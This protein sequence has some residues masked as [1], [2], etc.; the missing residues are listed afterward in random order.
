MAKRRSSTATRPPTPSARPDGQ[1]AAL[2]LADG[3]DRVVQG[4]LLAALAAVPL[5]FSLLD[6]TYWETDKAVLLT[7]FA[8]VAGA[9]WLLGTL[10]RPA[11][12]PLSPAARTL[13]LL[14]VAVYGAYVLGTILSINPQY[15]LFGSISRHEGLITRTA[16][17]VF[18]VCVLTRVR[19]REQI[20]RTLTVVLFG[21]IPALA[22]GIFQKF[23]LDPITSSGD[24]AVLLFPVR[25]TFGDHIF[26]GAYLVLIIPL[27]A[28]RAIRVWNE[29]TLRGE[30]G[31]GDET[32]LAGG[33]VLLTGGS[34]FGLLALTVRSAAESVLLPLV[35]AAY[36]GFGLAVESMPRTRGMQRFRLAGYVT[37]LL[38]EVLD[39]LFTSAR[40][41]E[42]GFLASIPAFLFLLAWY[43]RR[44]RAWI[45]I[46][47]VSL[48]AGAFFV[49]LNVP[50]GP[51]ERLRHVHGLSSISN[52]MKSG[53]NES[54]A[55]GRLE[56]WRGVVTLIGHTP[57]VG[58]SWAGPARDVVGYGPDTMPLAFQRVFP[59]RLRQ[60]TFE[61]YT[62]DRAHD[63]YLDIVEEAGFLALLAFLGT[64]GFALWYVLR[65]LRDWSQSGALL[66]V[67]L[68]SAIVGHMIEGVFGIETAASL[69]LLW[70][71]V[72][73]VGS[74]PA[75]G[76]ESDPVE[77]VPRRLGPAAIYAAGVAVL[78]LLF[79]L[80]LDLPAHP[81]VLAAIWT[82]G[83][84]GAAAFLSFLVWPATAPEPQ[85][86]RPDQVRPSPLGGRGRAVAAGVGL[87]VVLG[88]MTQFRLE[89]AAYA[90][91]RG[92][93]D[94]VHGNL[95]GGLAKAQLA[96]QAAGYVDT[97]RLD[98][99]QAYLSLARLHNSSSDPR[100]HPTPADARSLDPQT[101]LTLGKDQLFT[102]AV[103][104]GRQAI[105]ATPQDPNAYGTVGDIYNEW[106]KNLAAAAIFAQAESLSK[107]N[108][109]YL[110]QE[111]LAYLDAGLAERARSLAIQA[112]VF[113]QR[114]WY[115]HY[116]QAIILRRLGQK[117]AAREQ[118]R[119]G[120]FWAPVMYP[121]VPE[122]DLALLRRIEK[123]G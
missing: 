8:V 92:G 95:T 29:R 81:L 54:S 70:V 47:L 42:L 43:A 65:G 19:T 28:A 90:D 35:F 48:V 88:L 51:L 75:T 33:L 41:P 74:V 60:E 38:V 13:L 56:I 66:A 23:H 100:Y 117:V 114:F 120:L 111:A 91:G 49:G 78:V 112:T 1:S 96:A 20:D 116:T 32:L 9:A 57:Q 77:T 3:S 68:A 71:I 104:A 36:A 27:T 46:L 69:L 31:A 53:G 73:A 113:D 2:R 89:A 85:R 123:T 62:W 108:P 16:Y 11:R 83:A 119:L 103:D 86:R 122:P 72:G 110:D 106:G 94:F 4:T 102:L 99:A 44:R 61:V 52:I 21:A 109:R 79:T 80:P 10:L 45:S 14:G 26:F 24:P 59:L 12:P 121:P 105:A 25:S 7:V 76:E 101:A 34:I 98:L 40:G 107:Q 15:S 118:A 87:V 6:T 115:S 17:L 22:Y 39:L 93:V 30:R 82:L 37:L 18:F 5:Y 84:V 67:G 97:Y 55:Q 63:I 50:G 64:L 58:T